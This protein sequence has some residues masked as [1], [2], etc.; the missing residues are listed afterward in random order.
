MTEPPRRYDVTITVDRDRDSGHLPNPAEFA[1]TAEQVASTRAASIVSAHTASQII[2]TVTVL[3]ADQLAAVAVALAVVSDVLRRPV[4]PSARQRDLALLGALCILSNV[5]SG[6]APRRFS[7][8]SCAAVITA[9]S[10]VMAHQ[11]ARLADSE[12]S[13]HT[14]TNAWSA[15]LR[16]SVGLGTTRWISP[17]SAARQQQSCAGA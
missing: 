11:A 4:A 16:T 5:R 13:P 17:P 6:P 9:A 15:S 14:N 1:V 10:S 12:I 2:S 7:P 8:G 3:A